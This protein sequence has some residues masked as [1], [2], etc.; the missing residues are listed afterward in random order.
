MSNKAQITYRFERQPIH[1]QNESTQCNQDIIVTRQDKQG[2]SADQLGH[3]E[4]ESPGHT[5]VGR[6]QS[7]L[8]IESSITSEP[9]IEPMKAKEAAFDW[10]HFPT[11]HGPWQSP[12]DIETE[13]LERIIREADQEPQPRAKQERRDHYFAEFAEDFAEESVEQVD[14]RETLTD[15]SRLNGGLPRRD[16]QH[17]LGAQRV[18]KEQEY[19]DIKFA[20][21]EEDQRH[22]FHSFQ[23][24]EPV[25]TSYSQRSPNHWGKMLI[26]VLGAILTGGLFGM[27]VLSLFTP[28]NNGPPLEMNAMPE[29]QSS[30]DMVG[31]PVEFELEDDSEGVLQNEQHPPN[32]LPEIDEVN[33][34]VA[35]INIPSK[36]YYVLQN[37]M[38]SSAEGAET[39]MQQLSNQGFAAASELWDHYYVYAGI[40]VNRDDALLLSHMLHEEDYETYIKAINLPTVRAAQWKDDSA[41]TLQE[42]IVQGN[43]VAEIISSLT[44]MHLQ[45]ADAGDIDPTFMNSISTA[46]QAWNTLSAAVH[47]GVPEAS[48]ATIQKMDTALNTAMISL[49]AYN[50][51][52]SF[53]YLW[54]AQT[55]LI[56][57]V[58]LQKQLLQTI[59]VS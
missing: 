49:E 12:Y 9:V 40:S 26:A 28:A 30:G 36:S 22:H 31:I 8:E 21:R 33:L 59:A 3:D 48:K 20:G 38:F 53:S 51:N 47:D 43:Q 4:V 29:Q 2:E 16:E 24:D 39:A 45:Q 18:G 41:E 55:T 25:L 6:E 11:Q 5:V 58:I 1:R 13:E 54:Q 10:R 42:Y 46:H 52:P 50:K 15:E 7:L 27:F 17:D 44:V 35:S 23:H 56:N 37:G 34:E 19:D 32:I 14:E 57:Y